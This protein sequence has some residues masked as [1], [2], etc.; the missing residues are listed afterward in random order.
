MEYKKCEHCGEEIHIRSKKC[1]FCNQTV[2]EVV[3]EEI[4]EEQIV[5]ESIK[6]ENTFLSNNDTSEGASN[7]NN[8]DM[9]YEKNNITVPPHINFEVGENGTPKDYV[10]KAEVRHSL[11][12]T[13]QLSNMS[14]VFIAALCTLPIIG[15]LIGSFMGV[16]FITYED[17]DRRSFGKAL[18]WLSIFMVV[19]YFAYIRYAMNLLGTIDVDSLYN[20]LGM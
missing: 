14:K 17:S 19:L 9:N 18:I 7:F 12:Y 3:P 13:N 8:E 16:F 5:E 11:E 4:K 1:P 20:S 15:Q 2:A 10:Y 6:E